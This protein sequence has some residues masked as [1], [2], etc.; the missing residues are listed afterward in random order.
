MYFDLGVLHLFLTFLRYHRERFTDVLR[1]VLKIIFS[2]MWATLLPLLYLCSF[3]DASQQV[4]GVLPFLKHVNSVQPLYI[5]AVVFYLLPN[6]LE[7]IVLFPL[8]M[9]RPSTKHSD[10]YTIIRF[11]LW[12]SQ[13]SYHL[14]CFPFSYFLIYFTW[15]LCL[16]YQMGV[17]Y[18]IIFQLLL[19]C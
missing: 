16:P 18:G 5:I 9:L 7:A 12:W 2:F 15:H 10:R 14:C 11:L 13:V 1:N 6:L 8:L 19:Y 3:E 4:V 17:C